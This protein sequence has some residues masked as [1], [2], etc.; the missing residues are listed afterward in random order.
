MSLPGSEE[1]AQGKDTRRE[2][3]VLRIALP[4]PAL[5]PVAD[6]ACHFDNTGGLMQSVI[7]PTLK[8]LCLTALSIGLGMWRGNGGCF[9]RRSHLVGL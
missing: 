8:A 7:R 4:R 6:G 3:S 5:R 1:S 9:G 2:F